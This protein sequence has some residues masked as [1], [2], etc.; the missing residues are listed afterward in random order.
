MKSNCMVSADKSEL[1]AVG[2]TSKNINT[3]EWRNWQTCLPAGASRI[4][5]IKNSRV[6]ELAD[7]LD[8]GSSGVTLGGSTPPP[9]TS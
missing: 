3:G 8:L 2:Q 4:L 1:K 7:A 6:A 5:F 9:R